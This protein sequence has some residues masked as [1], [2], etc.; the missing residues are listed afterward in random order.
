MSNEN[1]TPVESVPAETVEKTEPC[2]ICGKAITTIPRAR[3]LHMKACTEKKDAEARVDLPETS[4]AQLAE[5]VAQARKVA[6]I[7]KRQ[8]PN[9]SASTAEDN[10]GMGMKEQMVKSLGKIP[11]GYS[12]C[13]RRV[14]LRAVNVSKGYEPVIVDGQTV[15]EN[16]VELYIIPTVV[17]KAAQE[18]Y[19]LESKRRLGDLMAKADKATVEKQNVKP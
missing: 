11:D 10:S 4:D 1:E 5:Y 2:P 12:M 9:V 7:R 3:M 6:A 16:E 15:R 19:S 14:D 13:W 17:T 18:S 8:A